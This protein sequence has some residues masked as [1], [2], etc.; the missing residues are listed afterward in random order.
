MLL[1]SLAGMNALHNQLQEFVLSNSSQL[2][3]PADQS[4]APAPYRELLGGLEIRKTEAPLF[5]SLTPNRW[6]LLTGS[7]QHLTRYVSFFRFDEDEEGAH[8]HPEHVR[9]AEYMSSGTMSLIIEVDSNWI[10]E[11]RAE[12]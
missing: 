12:S 2:A 11:L 6:L 1:D 8:H 9:E 10:D 4:G 7:Q 3:V 5:L